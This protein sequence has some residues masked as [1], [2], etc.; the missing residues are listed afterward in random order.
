[1]KNILRS[2]LKKINNINIYIYIQDKIVINKKFIISFRI[3]K[4]SINIYGDI[5]NIFIV[6][7]HSRKYFTVLK[8]QFWTRYSIN[9]DRK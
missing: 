8:I 1:M 7:D 3:D 5:K 9:F 4:F 2:R 6:S